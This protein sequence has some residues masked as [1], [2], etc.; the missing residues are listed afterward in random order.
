MKKFMAIVMC[1]AMALSMMTVVSFAADATLTIGTV[2][3]NPGDVV[4]VP[5][6]FKATT[7]TS[8]VAIMLN[9]ATGLTC[10]SVVIDSTVPVSSVANTNL[11]MLMINAG[12]ASAQATYDGCIGTYT[13][14]VAD[15][16]SGE[17]ALTTKTVA[18]KNGTAA[19]ACDVVAGKIIVSGGQ[20]GVTSY[21]VV[22]KD[23]D[24]NEIQNSAIEEGNE[25]GTL[26]TAPE[27]AGYTFVG[28]F[29][30]DNTEIKADTVV[31]SDITAT[32]K[33]EENASDV[34]KVTIG[35][36]EATPGAVVEVP[37]YFKTSTTTTQVAVMLNPVTGLTCQNIVIDPTVPASAVANTNLNML[38]INAGFASAQATYDGCI[39]TYTF[40]VADNAY[41]GDIVLTT[42]TVAVK[43][44]NVT[45]DCDVIAGKITVQAV[46]I[47]LLYTM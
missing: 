19:V 9:A 31:E 36:V 39:G 33:Y 35:T 15:N 18:V 45:V 44:G 17:I 16:A 40:K 47:V 29:T 46:R 30:D 28:W 32:A 43:N 4:E 20:G 11:G 42:K 6:Y 1:L 3:A 7:T 26:P 27:K 5:V 22:F 24:G 41:N 2:E 8:Q 25:I 14:K 13:F 10:Q 23:A 12:F 34:T 21:N 38:M 37:V